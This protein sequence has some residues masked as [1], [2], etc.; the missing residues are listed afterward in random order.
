MFLFIVGKIMTKEINHLS[1]DN[2]KLHSIL[3]RVIGFIGNCDTKVSFWLSSLGVIMTI[4]SAVNPPTLGFIRKTVTLSPRN[5]EQEILLFIFFAV[6]CISLCRFFIGL[7]FFSKALTANIKLESYTS[8]IFFGHI[9]L[10]ESYTDYITSL[11][12]TSLEEYLK[13]LASQI[14]VN[15][16][17]CKNKFTY[18]N[19]GVKFCSYSLI[20]LIFSWLYIFQ[21]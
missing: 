6:F 10:K 8:N 9:A 14:Y 16:T 19:K 2:D 12:N 20:F 21:K 18:Y 1:D 17:I 15:S 4:L 3:E 5:L 13:D 11:E 7:Y